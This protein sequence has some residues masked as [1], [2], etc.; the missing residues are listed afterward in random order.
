MKLK[1]DFIV[2][3]FST[4]NWFIGLPYVVSPG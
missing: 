2:L 3:K 1:I 4:L